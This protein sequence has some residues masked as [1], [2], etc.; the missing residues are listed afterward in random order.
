MLAEK[1]ASRDLRLLPGLRTQGG[2]RVGDVG[3][4]SESC[5]GLEPK[6]SGRNTEA[7]FP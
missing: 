7:H 4:E 5:K 3:L 6:R 2:H 1:A